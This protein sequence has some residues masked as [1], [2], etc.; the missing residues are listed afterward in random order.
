MGDPQSFLSTV[1][2]ASTAKCL[3][4]LYLTSQNQSRWWLWISIVNIGKF[5]LKLVS[6]LCLREFSRPNGGSSPYIHRSCFPSPKSL[7]LLSLPNNTQT[8]C[9][10]KIMIS[11]GSSFYLEIHRLGKLVA[12]VS[13]DPC[14]LCKMVVSKIHKLFMRSSNGGSSI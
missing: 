3:W 9:I 1:Q 12:M 10:T 5:R 4:T 8:L 13:K 7:N 11:R 14:R 6:K 2:I